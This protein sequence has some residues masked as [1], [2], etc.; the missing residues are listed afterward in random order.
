MKVLHPIL[1]DSRVEIDAKKLD[2]VLAKAQAYDE[3]WDRFHPVL[4]RVEVGR[5]A[6]EG[7]RSLLLGIWA[8]IFEA[9]R[10]D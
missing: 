3:I 5:M 1:S 7:M 4:E 6:P 9:Y 8:S 2:D 10:T